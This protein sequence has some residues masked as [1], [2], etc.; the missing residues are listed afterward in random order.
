MIANGLFS[1]RPNNTQGISFSSGQFSP[2]TNRKREMVLELHYGFE[3]TR[4]FSLQPN[5]QW[6]IHP[7]GTDSIP[8]ALT[9]GVQTVV[10]F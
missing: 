7:G 1:V 3:V 2:S 8:D 4:W 10:D 6:I 5:I 9:L